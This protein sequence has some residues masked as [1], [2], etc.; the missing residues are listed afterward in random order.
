VALDS[1]NVITEPWDGPVR[2]R[3]R[4]GRSDQELEGGTYVELAATF[5]SNWL[6]G[7]GNNAAHRL[8]GVATVLG[9]FKTVGG[10]DPGQP[11]L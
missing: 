11:R 4:V 2:L 8:T 5:L 6:L 10:A 7:T 3:S 9:R 1:V